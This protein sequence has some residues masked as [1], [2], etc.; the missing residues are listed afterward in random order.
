MRPTWVEISL[1]ELRHNFRSVQDFVAPGATALVVVKA[2]AYGHGAVECARAL[3]KEGALWLGVSSTEEGVLLRQAGISGRILLMSGF[4]RWD[5][6]AIIEH[7]LTAAVWDW[8]QI[9]LLEHAAT[10]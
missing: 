3:E 7:D 6:Q 8:N 1:D 5:E 9:E 4:W 10:K 2:D